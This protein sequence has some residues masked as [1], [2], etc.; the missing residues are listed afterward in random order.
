MRPV[1]LFACGLVLA[2]M[3]AGFP[4]AVLAQNDPTRIPAPQLSPGIVGEE[5]VDEDSAQMRYSMVLVNGGIAL[6][7]RKTGTMEYCAAQS[8][9]I[10]CRLAVEERQGYEDEIARLGARVKQLEDKLPRKPDATAGEDRRLNEAMRHAGRAL[11]HI[12]DAVKDLRTDME[13]GKG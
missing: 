4:A 2:G 6:L 8:G 1:F 12:F 5:I 9:Q 7:D 13:G 11:R 10:V 3:V